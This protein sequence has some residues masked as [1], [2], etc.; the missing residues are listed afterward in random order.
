MTR[1]YISEDNLGDFDTPEKT[2]FKKQVY[3]LHVQSGARRRDF[4]D[5]LPES[6][7]GTIE[8]GHKARK[9]AA[10]ACV[11]LLAKAREDLE[12][13]KQAREAAA[14]RVRAIGVASAYRSAQRQFRIWDRNFARYYELTKDRR[15]KAPGGEHGDAA[16]RLLRSFIA[17]RLAAPGFSLHNNGIAIDFTT[18]EG[19]TRLGASKRQTAEWKRAWFYA[20]LTAHAGDFQFALNPHIDE[21]WHWE[22]SGTVTLM[23]FEPEEIVA[24]SCLTDQPGYAA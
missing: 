2:A 3:R 4:S 12:A 1:T 14:T 5:V 17:G 15:R 8:D 6:R 18:T 24:D 7:L 11:Q 21:P 13:A 20:W 9:D 10:A 19:K 23:Q 22:L 16:A